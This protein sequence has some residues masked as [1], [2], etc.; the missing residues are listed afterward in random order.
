[1]LIDIEAGLDVASGADKLEGLGY[2]QTEISPGLSRWTEREVESEIIMYSRSSTNPHSV[3]LTS[4]ILAAAIEK[5]FNACHF[6]LPTAFSI[7]DHVH[8]TGD[9]PVRWSYI[10]VQS[11]PEPGIPAQRLQA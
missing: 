11:P 10:Y 4:V 2:A 8:P 1:M 9:T 3:N 7:F 5:A 6:P